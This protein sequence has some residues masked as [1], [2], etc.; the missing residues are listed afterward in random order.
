MS[1]EQTRADLLNAL[2]SL[3]HALRE[4]EHDA[5]EQGILDSAAMINDRLIEMEEK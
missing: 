3:I 5:Y 2:R 4:G 1:D